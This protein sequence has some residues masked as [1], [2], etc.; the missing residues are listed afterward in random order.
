M[1]TIVKL[2]TVKR[3]PEDEEKPA[4]YLKLYAF[5]E[6]ERDVDLKWLRKIPIN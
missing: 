3:G 2:R 5:M 6:M 1:V 4:E